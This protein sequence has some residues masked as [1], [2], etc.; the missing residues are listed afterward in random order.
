[1]EFEKKTY[2]QLSPDQVD[3]FCLH[4]QQAKILFGLSSKTNLYSS[5]IVTKG[6]YEDVTATDQK[7]ENGSLNKKTPSIDDDLQKLKDQNVANSQSNLRIPVYND[8]E[9]NSE[10]FIESDVYKKDSQNYRPEM[11]TEMHK[12]ELDFQRKIN[13][14]AEN[15]SS[16]NHS[17]N[18]LESYS[19][20][21]TVS[22][23]NSYNN[24]S[25]GS[26]EVAVSPRQN[27]KK[28]I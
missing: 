14:K 9:F 12:K 18:S 4:H 6:N 19:K 20:Q 2:I 1:M 17:E 24:Y 3:E 25:S 26:E 7:I 28:D 23:H 15:L 10:K 5:S 22:S 11:V 21:N 16:R 13:E 8:K 27:S